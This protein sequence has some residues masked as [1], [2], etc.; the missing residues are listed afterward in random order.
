MPGK[1]Q[2]SVYTEWNG[3]GQTL[4]LAELLENAR[5]NEALLQRLQAFELQL[6][7]AQNWQN[8]LTLLLD[9]KIILCIIESE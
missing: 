7:S 3:R 6:L 2:D 4:E 8:F 1:N 5:R 9:A